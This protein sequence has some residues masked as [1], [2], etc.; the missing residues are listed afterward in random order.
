MGVDKGAWMA[1]ENFFSI[2][3]FDEIT[4]DAYDLFDGDQ[5]T[6]IILQRN[7]KSYLVKDLSISGVQVNS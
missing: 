7:L 4:E 5:Y 3:T 2:P 6:V 1:F